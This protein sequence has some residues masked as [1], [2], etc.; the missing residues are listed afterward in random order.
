MDKEKRMRGIYDSLDPKE[1]Q[2]LK[3]EIKVLLYEYKADTAN[4]R[5]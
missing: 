4:F 5:R 1:I 3:D 2:R